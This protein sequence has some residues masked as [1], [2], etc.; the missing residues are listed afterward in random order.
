MS[1]IDELNDKFSI[2]DQLT[3]TSVA[4]EKLIADIETPLA[5][6]SISL[7]GGQVLTW[8]PKH[9][10]HP[11][12]WLSEK[13]VYAHG[14]AIRGGVPICWPWFGSH[15]TNSQLPGHG[16]ARISPW[17]ISSTQ[18]LS[19]GAVQIKLTM[20][21]TESSRI[22]WV[23]P[24]QLTS[25]ITVGAELSIELTTTNLGDQDIVFTE[26]L[27]TYF[28]ISDIQNI[29]VTGLEN[30]EYVDLIRDNA[31]SKQ[32]GP[33]TFDSELGRIFTNNS[34][35]CVIEDPGFKRRI[36]IDKL[37]S[38]STAVWNPWTET[39]SKM[40]DL[41]KD[42]WR[43]MV[44]VESANAL[45]DFVMVKRGESHTHSVVYRVEDIK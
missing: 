17:N 10:Q 32:E 16:F 42:G 4:D 25:C 11:V 28:K 7:I 12:L 40:S 23:Q 36:V 34:A 24:V 26:G 18:L 45:G 19:N 20:Q 43:D 22:H 15:P 37:G 39:A 29:R 41:G 3:F 38:L 9:Q 21:D 5:T 13:V 2:G 6:A 8:H 31:L 35:T 44:C 33:I 1:I 14:K 30:S 27:H